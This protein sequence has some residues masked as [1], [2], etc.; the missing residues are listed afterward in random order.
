LR[1]ETAEADRLFRRVIEQVRVQAQA[2]GLVFDAHCCAVLRPDP[3][4]G[5]R[6]EVAAMLVMLLVT[7]QL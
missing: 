7:D 1:E 6:I 4:P 3:D 5:T 2:A